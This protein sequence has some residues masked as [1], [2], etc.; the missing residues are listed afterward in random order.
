MLTI[1]ML[2][3]GRSIGE[4]RSARKVP[5]IVCIVEQ[6]YF[7]NKAGTYKPKVKSFRT[8]VFVL[9]TSKMA[10]KYSES[11]F[12]ACSLMLL[13]CGTSG[14]ETIRQMLHQTLMPVPKQLR[15]NIKKQLADGKV[16]RDASVGLSQRWQIMLSWSLSSVSH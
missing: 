3:Q 12:A 15:A 1:E 10:S 8:Q 16:S 14:Y 2:R 5:S 7:A 13:R 11:E 6:G 4:E 9:L